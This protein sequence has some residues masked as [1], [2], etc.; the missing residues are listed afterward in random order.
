MFGTIS[1]CHNI[2]SCIINSHL[3]YNISHWLVQVDIIEKA[4]KYHQVASSCSHHV[5]MW[6]RP[7]YVFHA[8]FWN[9]AFFSLKH[10]VKWHLT[11]KWRAGMGFI[12]KLDILA[13]KKAINQFSDPNWS[14]E[15][16]KSI[17]EGE[18]PEKIQKNVK[19]K[20]QSLKKAKIK[21]LKTWRASQ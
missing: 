14:G 19:K 16:A 10:Q 21:K 9:F 18:N 1:L 13:S 4:K 15:L 17:R 7:E 3:I 8:N 5:I 11:G 2:D 12:W 20:S 6:K